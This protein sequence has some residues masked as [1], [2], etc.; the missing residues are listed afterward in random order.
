M[1]KTVRWLIA[2]TL[3]LALTIGVEL[4]IGWRSILED[5]QALS[6][7]NLL[8]LTLLT[9]ISYLLRAERV[10]NYFAD[11]SHSRVSYIKISFLHNALNNFL[12]MRL[13]EPPS[14]C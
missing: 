14:L 5:W 10:F 3:F 12:P 7:T 9:F 8:L 1:S 2:T 11:R 4:T 6:V 13:G